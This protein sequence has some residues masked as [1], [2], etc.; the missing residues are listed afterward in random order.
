M[1]LKL[2]SNP[3][4][5]NF[6]R[7]IG[8]SVLAFF[9]VIK[10]KKKDVPSEVKKILLI[11][12]A[13]MGDTVLMIPAIRALREKYPEAQVDMLASNINGAIVENCPYINNKY[14]FE[15][16]K[17]ISKL[18]KN[19]RLFR[20]LRSNKYDIIIDF[21]PFVRLTAILSFLLRGRFIIGFKTEKQYKHI[22]YDASA[23]HSNKR[24]EVDNL[25]SLPALIGCTVLN[26]NLELWLPQDT[27]FFVDSLFKEAHIEAGSIVVIH[28]ATGGMNHPRQWPSEYYKK[29]IS[30]L[31]D[32]YDVK[33]ILLGGQSEIEAA[34]TLLIKNE[35]RIISFAG[36]TNLNQTIEII[37]RAN[38][39]ISGNTGTMHI[40]S[41]FDIPLIAFHGPTDPVRFGPLG[42]NSHFIQAKISC[43]P[44]L[45]LGFE[46][47]CDKY[48]C[49]SF[50]TPGEV[51][52]YIKL[53]NPL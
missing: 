35:D 36:L 20:L 52:E 49:M 43:S 24:H 11:R 37:K 27:G 38:L 5:R 41:V 6:D 4:V 14:K 34:E 32:A 29:L 16:S 2:K 9:S 42:K 28:P 13:A 8:V 44:C 40:A 10:R 23:E 1:R 22:A 18:K 53:N 25:L 30:F 19:I 48:P 21:E 15:F 46:Y 26:R 12:F 31:L 33:I 7:I 39:F 17:K 3:L 47:G 50:I 51:I 45:D